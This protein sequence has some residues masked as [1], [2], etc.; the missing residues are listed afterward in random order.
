[1]RSRRGVRWSEANRR[2]EAAVDNVRGLRV[3]GVRAENG[4]ISVP[5]RMKLFV[6][7]DRQEYVVRQFT[8]QD[9][10]NAFRLGK[11]GGIGG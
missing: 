4:R 11:I 9:S 1:M 2:I 8:A 5:E 10:S 3:W 6:L 7:V